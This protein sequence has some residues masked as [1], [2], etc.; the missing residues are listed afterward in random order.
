[1]VNVWYAGKTILYKVLIRIPSTEIIKN[2]NEESREFLNIEMF[3]NP[4]P[5]SIFHSHVPVP[6]S[7]SPFPKLLEKDQPSSHELLPSQY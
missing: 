2:P 7:P 3:K 5:I 4:S 1:M 6:K